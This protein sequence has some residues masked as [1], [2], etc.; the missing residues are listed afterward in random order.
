MSSFPPS[1]NPKA[2]V[3]KNDPSGYVTTGKGG[4]PAS[5]KI[6]NAAVKP[7]VFPG[8]SVDPSNTDKTQSVF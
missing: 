7:A 3:I 8:T 4:I 1:V 2:K 6:K 5:L